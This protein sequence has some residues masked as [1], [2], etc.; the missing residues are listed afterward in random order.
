MFIF[1]LI[2]FG[3]TWP[4]EKDQCISMCLCC[5]SNSN[6]SNDSS[7][8]ESKRLITYKLFILFVLSAM[9]TSLASIIQSRIGISQ[10]ERIIIICVLCVAGKD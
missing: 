3:R 4:P 6:L 10:S 5:C 9:I 7:E 2:V 8:K 1:W